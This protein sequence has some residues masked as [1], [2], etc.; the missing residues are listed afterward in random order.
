MEN[1]E[2]EKIINFLNSL[3]V[4]DK[5]LTLNELIENIYKNKLEGALKISEQSIEHEIEKNKQ[6]LESLIVSLLN[7]Y[8]TNIIQTVNKS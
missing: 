4:Q 3:D 8:S 5:E 2:I 1:I 7:R 6:F